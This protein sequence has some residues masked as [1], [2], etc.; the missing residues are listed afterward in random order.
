MLVNTYAHIQQSSRVELGKKF[1]EYFYAKTV[2]K[3]C[4]YSPTNK[5][6][7]F[8]HRLDGIGLSGR[9]AKSG[10]LLAKKS[11]LPVELSGQTPEQEALFIVLLHFSAH[12]CGIAGG[13]ARWLLQS[14]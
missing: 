13:F 14:G 5:I 10:S 11:R 2:Q 4:T 9:T 8:P 3:P 7:L 6:A 1:E 12:F